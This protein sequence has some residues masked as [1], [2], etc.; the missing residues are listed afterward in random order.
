MRLTHTHLSLCVAAEN[1]HTT[2]KREQT[3]LYTFFRPALSFV[4]EPSIIVSAC[5]HARTHTH[6]HAHTHAY[7]RTHTHTRT[8]ARTHTHTHTHSTC[9]QQILIIK[10]YR[11]L[12]GKNYEHLMTCCS[13]SCFETIQQ[14]I[15]THS[16]SHLYCIRGQ[17][18]SEQKRAGYCYC[19]CRCLNQLETLMVSIL[20]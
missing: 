18:A 14:N 13:C 12:R 8:H 16:H 9:M 15:C 10:L 5:V 3:V 20:V 2:P 7:V 17:L 11:N 4:T 6:T 1:G 19:Y